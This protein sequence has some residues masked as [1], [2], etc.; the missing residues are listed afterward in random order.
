[1]HHRPGVVEL[2]LLPVFS[3]PNCR[4]LVLPDKQLPH[5]PHAQI[6]RRADLPQVFVLA[7]SGKSR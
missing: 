6:A 5:A 7:A 3:Q 1:M 2:R 4:T